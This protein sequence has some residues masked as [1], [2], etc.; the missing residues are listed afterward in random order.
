[1]VSVASSAIMF[2]TVILT[3]YKGELGWI[4]PRARTRTRA[5]VFSRLFIVYL[6]S[7]L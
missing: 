5:A 1:L 6:L 2:S 7:V 4:D 3:G